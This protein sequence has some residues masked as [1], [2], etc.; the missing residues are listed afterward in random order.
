VQQGTETGSRI[1]SR[2]GWLACSGFCVDEDRKVD[3]RDLDHP[4][5][6]GPT[7]NI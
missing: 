2:S 1:R 3:P 4:T 7:F 6:K 5:S